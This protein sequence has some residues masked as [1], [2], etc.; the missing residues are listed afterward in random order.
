MLILAAVLGGIIPSGRLSCQTPS[1]EEAFTT[2]VGVLQEYDGRP[3]VSLMRFGKAAMVMGRAVGKAGT[4]WTRKVAK[5]FRHV[6]TVYMLEYGQADPGL[7]D[8][9]EG[10]VLE[11]VSRDNLIY[12]G[13]IGDSVFDETFGET[14]EDGK[15]VS[16]L[17]IV[18]YG[19][20][21]VCLQGDVL[22]TDVER[23]VRRLERQL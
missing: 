3:N 2:V 11:N 6:S 1:H 15:R 21:I 8:E 4:A 5:A 22:A 23:I 7:R 9:M 12:T 10:K 16:N 20:S 19:Q 14:S 17:V 13:R 18:M